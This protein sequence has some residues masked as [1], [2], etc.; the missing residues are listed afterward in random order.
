MAVPRRACSG[1][2]CLARVAALL[3]TWAVAHAAGPEP[4]DAG[5][6]QTPLASRDAAPLMLASMPRSALGV[7]EGKRMKDWWHWTMLRDV[8]RNQRYEAAV[9]AAVAAYHARATAV[10]VAQGGGVEPAAGPVVVELGAGGGL[11][12]MVAARAGA[13]RVWAIE[14]N[15]AIVPALRSNL[16]RNGFG[17]GGADSR[18]VRVLEGMSYNAT[19]PA[20][21][22]ADIVVHEVFGAGLMCEDAHK[23]VADARIRLA[24]PGAIMVPAKA[25]AYAT[26]VYSEAVES[27][28]RLPDDGNVSGFDMRGLDAL[29]YHTFTGRSLRMDRSPVEVRTAHIPLFNLDFRVMPPNSMADF[30]ATRIVVVTASGAINAVATWW[31]ADMDGARSNVVSTAPWGLGNA[32]MRHPHWPYRVMY[33]GQPSGEPLRV[34]TGDRL[35]ITVHGDDPCFIRPYITAINGVPVPG[36]Q[37]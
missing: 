33:A 15:A 17:S 31:E 34:T 11:L 24:K 8:D 20:A 19:V 23:S 22:L 27:L 37:H 25:S 13:R 35:T 12:A 26:F 7:D 10:A 18:V 36:I 2:A 29:A 9:V 1:G 3:L 16:A 14:G 6:A 28:T 21:E 5:V 4:G 30:A 32:D